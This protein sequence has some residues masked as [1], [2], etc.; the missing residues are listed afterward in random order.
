M[1][2]RTASSKSK[3]SVMKKAPSSKDTASDKSKPNGT[4]PL[5][6][7]VN[8]TEDVEMTEDGKDPSRAPKD[9]EDEMT[10]VV[11]P[12][13]SS[14]LTAEPGKDHGEDTEMD[15]SQDAEKDEAVDTVDPKA[16]AISGICT[17]P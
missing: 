8:G 13:K 10:V 3:A 15:V 17:C 2:A 14:K 5:E 6:N 4:A 16:K 12:P 1:P 9:G 11:P 7:G